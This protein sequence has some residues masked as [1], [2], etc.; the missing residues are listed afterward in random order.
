MEK[1]ITPEFIDTRIDVLYE[2]LDEVVREYSK[3]TKLNLSSII[4]ILE[5]LKQ[6]LINENT[7]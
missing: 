6:T 4:G 3:E 7:E 1:V 2:K 5:I